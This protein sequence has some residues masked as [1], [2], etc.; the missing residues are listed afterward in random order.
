MIFVDGPGSRARFSGTLDVESR[1]SFF[2]KMPETSDA[3]GK[4]IR[5]ISVR[6]YSSRRSNSFGVTREGFRNNA[7]AWGERQWC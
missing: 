6:K 4:I 3:S 7:A 1:A 5:F 2:R